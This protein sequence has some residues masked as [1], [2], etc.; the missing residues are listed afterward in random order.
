MGPVRFSSPF[1]PFALHGITIVLSA[2][3]KISFPEH[4]LSKEREGTCSTGQI[5]KRHKFG[6]TD[7]LGETAQYFLS[8]R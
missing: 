5:K 7:R 6:M 1:S 4:S 2:A 8:E 3:E